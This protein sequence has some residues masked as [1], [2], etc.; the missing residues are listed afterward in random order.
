MKEGTYGYLFTCVYILGQFTLNG[1]KSHVTQVI[2]IF[3]PCFVQVS[4]QWLIC[5]YIQIGFIDAHQICKEE[6]IVPT[7]FVFN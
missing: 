4:Y 3:S 7:L 5:K 2:S 6:L 1:C